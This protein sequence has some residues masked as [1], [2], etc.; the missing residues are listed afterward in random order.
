MFINYEIIN[1]GYHSIFLGSS[2]PISSLADI[3]NYYDDVT[4]ISYFT[5]KP[6]KDII[7]SYIDDFESSI[8]KNNNHQFWI[9]GQMLQ[10]ID[11]STLPKSIK[12]FKTIDSLVKEI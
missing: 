9:L 5:V 6:E 8:L 2:V 3:L 7:I 10:Y 4:F 12:P 1:K 11:L